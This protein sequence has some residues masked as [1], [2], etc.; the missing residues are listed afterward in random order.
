MI[1]RRILAAAIW[2]AAL[3]LWTDA[4]APGSP[5]LAPLTAHTTSGAQRR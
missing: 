1:R 4:I 3:A 5:L 2:A